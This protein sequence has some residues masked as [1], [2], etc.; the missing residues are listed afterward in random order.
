MRDLDYSDELVLEEL[1][2]DVAIEYAELRLLSLVKDLLFF[3]HQVNRVH[4]KLHL[5]TGDFL[6][7]GIE[8]VLQCVL[9]IS[10]IIVIFLVL[11]VFCNLT[12]AL[13]G[14]A[15]C[16]VLVQSLFLV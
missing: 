3:E 7:L 13:L 4:L 11:V 14:L 2:S 6:D 1:E 10:I 9:L 8:V 5:L 16:L 12:G 15:L